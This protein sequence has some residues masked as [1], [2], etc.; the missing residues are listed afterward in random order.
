VK[1]L[2]LKPILIGVGVTILGVIGLRFLDR[3]F[4]K[5]TLADEA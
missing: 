5:A 3:K 2:K 4:P 1:D